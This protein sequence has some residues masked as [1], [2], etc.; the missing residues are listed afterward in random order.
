MSATKK[1]AGYVVCAAASAALFTGCAGTAPTTQYGYEAFKAG[2][3]ETTAPAKKNLLDTICP[4]ARDPK[5][6]AQLQE[7]K[8]LSA[9]DIAMGV[10]NTALVLTVPEVKAAHFAVSSFY[11][12]GKYCD[13]WEPI[14]FK[15]S[16]DKTAEFKNEITSTRPQATGGKPMKLEL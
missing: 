15:K 4:G 1:I 10:A 14:S 6:Q 8:K 9:S 12:L 5:N 3:K 11:D 16:E 7:D 13:W 2:A